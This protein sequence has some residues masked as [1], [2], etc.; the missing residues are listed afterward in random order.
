MST[1]E[2]YLKSVT[3]EQFQHKWLSEEFAEESR[4]QAETENSKEH[5]YVPRFYLDRWTI[6]GLVQPTQVD[7]GVAYSPQRPKDVGKKT[8]FYSIPQSEDTMDLPLKWVEKHLSRIESDC[9]KHFA[10]MDEMGASKVIEDELKRDMAVFLALQLA[11]TP[12]NRERSLVI[13]NGPEVAKREWLKRTNPQATAAQ[14]RESLKPKYSDPKREA[15]HLM[16]ADARNGGAQGLYKRRWAIYQSTEPIATCDDPVIAIAGPTVP[17]SMSLGL[18]SAAIIYPLGPHQLLV[19]LR[20]DH[21]HRSPLT[22]TADEVSS[23]NLE[24][25]STATKTAFERPGDGIAESFSVPARPAPELDDESVSN[26]SP[27]R[28]LAMLLHAATRRRRW[29]D[30]ATAPDWPV[31]RWYR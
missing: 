17:R 10:R 7:A 4:R 27:E 26:L 30:D 18:L 23:V 31:P 22:L 21:H 29:P 1:V 13:I 25:V 20:P 6:N 19:M 16:L 24:I 11:R 9:I 3:Q 5:H 12:S 28:A 8:N 14:V 15:L 2:K